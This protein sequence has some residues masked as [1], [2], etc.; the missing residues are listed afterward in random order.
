M[1]WIACLCRCNFFEGM[2]EYTQKGYLEKCF[3]CIKILKAQ[4]YIHNYRKLNAPRKKEYSLSSAYLFWSCIDHGAWELVCFFTSLFPH[5]DKKGRW[6]QENVQVLG[7]NKSSG[8]VNYLFGITEKHETGINTYPRLRTQ[9]FISSFH[10]C[11]PVFAFCTW[12]FL[13][14]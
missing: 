8:Q 14:G 9:I 10:Q 5:D 13:D 11:E 3:S 12:I 7:K 4:K 1:R 6:R 2:S